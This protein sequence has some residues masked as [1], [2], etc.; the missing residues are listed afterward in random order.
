FWAG[1][2][3]G[4]VATWEGPR[5]DKGLRRWRAVARSAAR[6][7]R[8]AHIPAVGGVLSTV[9]RRWRAVARSAA[10]QSRRAHI[11]AVGGVLS[12]VELIGRVGEET[13]AGSAVLVLHE[14]ATDRL[15]DTHVAQADSVWLVVGPE[16][17]V[18]PEEIA[19]LTDAG[20]VAVR[21]GPQVLR[22]STAAAVALGALGVLTP[23]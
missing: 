19:A 4:G 9:E 14:S 5:V 22:T 6:Q 12:T 23:R 2:R 11:P 16:G 3:P 1:G 10:R 13:A 17:G 20:A 18:A 21:L 7:S 8:R 15:A